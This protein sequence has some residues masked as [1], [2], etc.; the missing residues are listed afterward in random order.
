MGWSAGLL[1]PT[2]V[3]PGTCPTDPGRGRKTLRLQGNPGGCG[4]FTV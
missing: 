2:V 1:S 4:V 3:G